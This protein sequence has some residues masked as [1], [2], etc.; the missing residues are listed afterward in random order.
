MNR[1]AGVMLVALATL[2]PTG[3]GAG[4]AARGA[5]STPC[6]AEFDLTLSPGLSNTPSSG[7]FTSGGETGTV[8]C[9]GTVNGRQATGPGTWGAEGRY[10]TV[11]P[12]SCTSGGEGEVIQSFTVPTADGNE[13]V[14]NEGTLT[15]GALEGGGLISGTFEGPRF[16][17][18]FDVTPTEGDCVT[19][20]ITRIHVSLRGTLTS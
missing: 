15:Y 8:E 14:V 20:P 7:T 18:T 6:T 16:S 5:E 1:T 17:G 13:H 12:D 11:D 19:A 4:D 9:R 3:L 2:A 10:G